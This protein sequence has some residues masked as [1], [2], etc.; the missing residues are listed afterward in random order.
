MQ[1][2]LIIVA[3]IFISWAA[4]P[5]LFLVSGGFD[6]LQVKQLEREVAAGKRHSVMHHLIRGRLLI[7]WAGCVLLMAS[8]LL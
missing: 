8:L 7:G 5:L 1:L 3:A 6:R 2:A 4:S